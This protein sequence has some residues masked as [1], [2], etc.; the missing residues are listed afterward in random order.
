MKVSVFG[1]GYVGAVTAACLARA[2][3]EVMGVDVQE[4]KLKALMEGKSPMVEPGLDEVLE[5]ARAAGRLQTSADAAEALAYSEVCVICVGTPSLVSGGLN[6]DFVRKVCH[7]LAQNLSASRRQQVLVFRSTML[8]GSTRR[9]VEEFF[10]DLEHRGQVEVLFAPEFLREGS[11]VADFVQPSL[12]AMGTRDGTEPRCGEV[13]SLFGAQ[14]ALLNWEAAE[15]LKYTC[16]YWHALKVAFANEVGRLGKHLQL[17][18]TALM[19]VFARDERLNIS[20]SYLRPGAPYGGSCLPKDL[21]ALTALVRQEGLLLPL[22]EATEASNQAHAQNLLKLVLRSGSR[23]VGLLGLSFK[24]GTDDLRGSPMV[25]LA[26]ALLSRGVELRIYD[27]QLQMSQVHGANAAEMR[28]R[29]PKLAGLLC[30]DPSEVLDYAPVLVVAQRC[31]SQAALSRWA[32]PQHL[33]IDLMGWPTLS[34]SGCRYEG[35]CW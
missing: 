29:L 26:E 24:A 35:I 27:P 12:A 34:T 18:S 28:R 14:P 17:D 19:E 30:A 10:G 3:H 16:N 9:L 15:L 21:S 13:L 11:A 2:G 5:Q 32:Q 20:R 6:L 25:S 8:P 23:R 31:V 33:L 22:L 7:Q 4:A 1:L